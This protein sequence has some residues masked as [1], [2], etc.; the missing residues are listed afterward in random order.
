MS[1]VVQGFQQGRTKRGQSAAAPDMEGLV[2]A[3]LRDRGLSTSVE[4]WQAAEPAI[5][6][7]EDMD[8][9]LLLLQ[10]EPGASDLLIKAGEPVRMRIDGAYRRISARS[11]S[12]DEI[13]E[14]AVRS[15]GSSAQA[16]VQSR[17]RLDFGH[18]ISL[19]R[20]EQARY[21]ANISQLMF[22]RGLELVVRAIRSRPPSLESLGME[23]EIVEAHRGLSSGMFL[24]VGGTGTGKSTSLA[25]MI[26][27]R[28][29]RLPEHVVCAEAPI[30]YVY[31]SCDYQGVVAQSE[32]PRD[33]DSFSV[34]MENAFRRDPDV[35]LVGEMRDAD[36][37]Q[38]GILASVSGHGV[39][40]TTHVNSVA[41]T[42]PRLVEAFS[43]EERGS[44][45]VRLIDSMRC[46]VHQRLFREADGPGRFAVRE[47]LVFTPEVR[48]R[49]L[50]V[51]Q[52][53]L[54]SE[55]R[56]LMRA[57]RTDMLTQARERFA[58][59]LREVDM[60]MLESEFGDGGN[61]T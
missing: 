26:D 13:M 27:D 57:G 25:A 52:E 44:M 43:A 58:D 53:D 24:M 51:D 10:I 40:S 55:I 20:H 23:P 61:E 21:R 50:S 37:I 4:A 46:I 18:G 19:S 7:P 12:A 49:L 36:T 56:K 29:K 5:L 1:M 16:Q 2:L 8:H 6:R 38:S 35:I 9:L 60:R 42:I 22:G 30:E 31:E 11:I 48:D 59:R 32:I 15:Y 54:V 39:Y 45:V 41:L 33:I 17:G 28:L 47:W 34:A 3:L 14:W